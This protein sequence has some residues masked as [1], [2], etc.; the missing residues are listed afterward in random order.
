[1][2]TLIPVVQ[3][4]GCDLR[5]Q[6]RSRVQRLAFYASQAW[7]LT[8]Q[9]RSCQLHGR[10]KSRDRLSKSPEPV[11]SNCS[12]RSHHVLEYAQCDEQRLGLTSTSFV[13][14]QA[15]SSIYRSMLPKQVEATYLGLPKR[16]GPSSVIQCA[17]ISIS[18]S[19]KM[20]DYVVPSRPMTERH[21]S[22][23]EYDSQF[24]AQFIDT[25]IL[26]LWSLRTILS[27]CANNVII[28]SY[29]DFSITLK[30]IN[31]QQKHTIMATK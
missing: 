27:I 25:I 14:T 31:S 29:F 21:A 18:T 19:V 16:G 20:F 30:H 2:T 10:S 1:M 7:L 13:I 6:L 12:Q 17:D 9:Q 26:S 23:N 15:L 8:R 22:R 24:A 28:V 5:V 3:T 11:R 4:E